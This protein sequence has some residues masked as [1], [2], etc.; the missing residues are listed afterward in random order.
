VAGFSTTGVPPYTVSIGIASLNPEDTDTV[1]LFDAA[2]KALYAAKRGGKN[3]VVVAARASVR[4]SVQR[5][6][7]AS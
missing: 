6:M 7:Q 3:R 5:E 2:D 4:G 1:S